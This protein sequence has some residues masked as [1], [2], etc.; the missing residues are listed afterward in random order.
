[1]YMLGEESLAA[2]VSSPASWWNH[3]ARPSTLSLL[4]SLFAV[5]TY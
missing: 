3:L 2:S 5:H 1:M 4:T